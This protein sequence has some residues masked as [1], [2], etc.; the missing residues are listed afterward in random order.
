MT[1]VLEFGRLNLVKNRAAETMTQDHTA[2]CEN[3]EEQ[4]EPL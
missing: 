4:M 1:N 3:P 2:V